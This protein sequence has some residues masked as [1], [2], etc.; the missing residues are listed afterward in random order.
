MDEF[1]ILK[2]LGIPVAEGDIATNE[3][4]AV[5]IAETIGYPVAMKIVSKDIQHKTDANAVKLNLTSRKEVESAFTE[6]IKNARAFRR[7]ARIEG[8]M[9]QRYYQGGTEVIVGVISDE[10]F[11]YAVMFGLGGIF[12]E[13]LKDV[14]YRIAPIDEKEALK[15]IKEIKSYPLLEG[16]RGMP[17]RDIDSLAKII[18]RF[19]RIGEEVRVK[20]AEINPLLVFEKGVTAVDFRIIKE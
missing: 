16:V 18:S 7:E 3:K 2:K 1:V 17:A 11:G 14:T 12:T 10:I 15:M 5:R 19:S 8:V 13:V 4:E 6:I 20:E 9:I